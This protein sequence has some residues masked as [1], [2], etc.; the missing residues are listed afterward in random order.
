MQRFGHSAA[1]GQGVLLPLR[2]GHN[3]LAAMDDLPVGLATP[4]QAVVEQQMGEGLTTQG[5]RHPFNPGEI[6]QPIL[7]GDGP[8]GPSPPAPG[9]AGLSTVAP[10]TERCV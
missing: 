6:T 1:G 4:G 7:P 2:E 3:T 9:H 8:A 10:A 5:D